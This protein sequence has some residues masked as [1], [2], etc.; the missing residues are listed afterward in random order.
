MLSFDEKQYT[1][2]TLELDGQTLTYRAYED[3]PYVAAP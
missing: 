3:I 1:I 2:K